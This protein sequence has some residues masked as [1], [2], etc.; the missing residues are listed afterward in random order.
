MAYKVAVTIKAVI[1]FNLFAITLTSICIIIIID[2]D[3][4][5][6]NCLR[7]QQDF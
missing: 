4:L 7:S 6:E 1:L 5:T 3:P 2:A